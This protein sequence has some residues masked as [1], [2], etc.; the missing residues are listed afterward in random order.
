MGG[1]YPVALDLRGRACLVVGG[2]AVA[3]RKAGGLLVAG[4]LV[5]VVAPEARPLPEG[6]IVHLRPFAEADLA[7]VALVVA[8]SDDRELNARIAGLARERGVWVNVADDPEA[9]DVILPA[10]ARRGGLQ[11]AV[12][13]GGASPA[14]AQRL[15][16]RLEDEFG[17]EYGELVALLGELRAAWEPRA[18]AAGVPPAARRAAWHAVL[19]LPLAEL[20][21]H[22]REAEAEERA[23]AVLE[24]ALADA[25]G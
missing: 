21:A 22:G 3:Q 9:G 19:D 11:V 17:P 5:T 7:D 25:A 14:L 18:I 23:R 4:A 24:R 2:G 13:T 1:Y 16:A 6:V 8:A 20:L 15:R 10:V 12:S